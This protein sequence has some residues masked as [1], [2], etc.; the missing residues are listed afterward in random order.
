M[1]DV[2]CGSEA[3][4]ALKPSKYTFGLLAAKLDVAPEEVLYVGNS[5]SADIEGASAIGMKTAYLMPLWRKI[6]NKPLP[7]A[8]ISF[9]N[10]RQ[11]QDFVLH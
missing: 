8:D 3:L 4:G 5:I 11:L 10:Y 9:K 2:V 7:I 1:F 6:F